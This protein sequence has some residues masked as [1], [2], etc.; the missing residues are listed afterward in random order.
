MVFPIYVYGHPVLRKVTGNIDK[1]Y[2]DLQQFIADMFETM[3][4]SDG[5]GLASPQAGKSVRFLLSIPPRLRIK[6]LYLRISRRYLSI[7]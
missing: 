4:D 6:T 7:H 3:Y 5:I 2:K 1:D